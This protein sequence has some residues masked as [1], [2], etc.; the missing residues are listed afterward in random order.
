MEARYG[1]GTGE[2]VLDDVK[3]TGDEVSLKECKHRDAFTSNCEHDEDVS[4][5]CFLSAPT[6]GKRINL[7]HGMRFP[8]I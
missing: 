4:V 3:C 6:T 8:T 2:I 7:S 5:K 1:Y